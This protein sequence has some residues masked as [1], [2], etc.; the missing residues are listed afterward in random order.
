MGEKV[1]GRK[2]VVAL[3]VFFRYSFPVDKHI[4]L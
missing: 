4:S 3:L 1:G 2:T